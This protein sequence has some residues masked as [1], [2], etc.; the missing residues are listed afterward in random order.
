MNRQ[1]YLNKA[2]QIL[3]NGNNGQQHLEN[4]QDFKN[5][6]EE[7]PIIGALLKDMDDYGGLIILTSD[8]SKKLQIIHEVTNIRRIEIPFLLYGKEIQK[9]KILFNDIY[10]EQNSNQSRLASFGSNITKDLEN[11]L[12]KNNSNL[13]ICHGHSHPPIG[14]YHKNFSHGD[15]ASYIEMNDIVKNHNSQSVGA[16]VTSNGDFNF[17]FYDDQSQDFYRFTRIL[18]QTENL[19]Y[20]RLNCYGKTFNQNINYDEER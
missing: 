3:I 10:I 2:K 7:C 17:L 8:V 6:G 20:V 5:N 14:D 1:D 4:F 12:N 11:R 15:L 9:N 18:E 13:V 16:I 19:D